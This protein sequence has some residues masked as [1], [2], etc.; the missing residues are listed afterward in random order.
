MIIERAKKREK[1][2]RAKE[3]SV[4]GAIDWWWTDRLILIDFIY[5]DDGRRGGSRPFFCF[6]SYCFIFG[7]LFNFLFKFFFVYPLFRSSFPR[8]LEIAVARTLSCFPAASD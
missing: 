6:Y 4:V 1:G 5:F 2:K 7:F 3:H 8:S